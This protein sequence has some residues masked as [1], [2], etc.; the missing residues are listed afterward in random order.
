M[1]KNNQEE[2]PPER[3]HS[4]L[5]KMGTIFII[6]LILL[7]PASLIKGLVNER[8][9]TKSEAVAEVGD[10][11]GTNQIITGPV[12]SIP[13]KS[14]HSN[15]LTNY[16]HILPESLNVNGEIIPQTLK[17]GIFE[18]A[19]Y[20][21]QSALSGKFEFPDLEKL[22]VDPEALML[23]Q[24][25]LNLGIS[26]MKGIENDIK[27]KWNN[28]EISFEPGVSHL[29]KDVLKTGISAPLTLSLSPTTQNLEN[30]DFKIQLNLKGSESLA[31]VPV[32]KETNVKI[33]SSWNSPSFNGDF[34][35]KERTI[36]ETGFNASWIV[37]HLNRNFP[38]NWKNSRPDLNSAAFGVDFYIPVDN[39]QKSERS[40]KYAILFIG[41]TF[42]VFFFIEVRNKRPVHPVQY[43][44]IGIALCFFYLLLVSISEHLSFNFSYLIASS[45]TIIMVTGFTKAVLKNTNL[46]LMMGSILSTLYLFIFM[47]IQLEDYALLTRSIGLFLIL[48]LIMF[49]SRKIDWYRL[50]NSLK[51]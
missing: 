5:W 51:I 34:V 24:A 35:P 10:K 47:L 19:V 25:R 7:I 15:G 50:N 48:G 21:S 11:W 17:R 1:P 3:D 6:T 18:I 12:L 13:Y 44:L 28:D 30:A 9:S 45:S 40:I 43:S 20:D 2:I 4:V 32:G 27:V 33:F 16:I 31:F 46:T 8:Q 36:T 42:L 38:Q 23:D 29:H 37:T 26:D 41:L 49:F 22:K 39:Y 14:G